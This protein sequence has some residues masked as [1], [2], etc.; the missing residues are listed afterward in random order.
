MGRRPDIFTIT[1]TEVFS[2]DFPFRM[3]GGRLS[4]DYPIHR[5]EFI[6]LVVILRGHGIHLVDDMQ[7]AVSAGDVFVVQ[8]E[9]AHGF[10]KNDDLTLMN[11]MFQPERLGL[12]FDALRALPGYHALFVLEPRWRRRHQF[13]SRLQLDPHTLA[14]VSGLVDRLERELDVRLP[15]Y[16]ALAIG[17]LLELLV[18]LCRSYSAATETST[19][20]LLHVGRV[21]SAIETHYTEPLT[22][23][24]LADLA[25]MSVNN[26][27]MLFKQATGHSP[28]DYLIRLR[29]EKGAVL[30]RDTTLSITDVA[31]RVGFADSNY[32]SRQFTRLI[33]I[34]PRA[35]R[36]GCEAG[37]PSTQYR[38][39]VGER[40]P[41]H[42]E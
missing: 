32:F 33:G 42:I 1:N 17:L 16:E 13:R 25:H 20:Q 21:I 4:A 15:G 23:A 3:M 7:Y 10:A 14:D 12:P 41:N 40:F 2:G 9:Q 5:H 36:Q 11:I 26:L 35:Y 37:L 39:T 22:L 34:A 24:Y 8:G 28:I 29:V 19:R 31:R 27:L 18:S 30:L 6:E 38:R